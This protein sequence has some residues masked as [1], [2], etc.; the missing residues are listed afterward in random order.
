MRRGGGGGGNPEAPADN[1]R[2]HRRCGV[3]M[4]QPPGGDLLSQPDTPVSSAHP[5]IPV[6]ALDVGAW[7][8]MMCEV[9]L[10]QARGGL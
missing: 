10:S 9:R 8:R 3:V 6:V 4:T 7:V 1:G 5:V 2:M